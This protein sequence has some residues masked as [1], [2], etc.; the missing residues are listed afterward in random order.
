MSRGVLGSA[1]GSKKIRFTLILRFQ[2]SRKRE[3]FAYGTW[4]RFGGSLLLRESWCGAVGC[5]EGGTLTASK[6]LFPEQNAEETSPTHPA[7]A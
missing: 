6:M 1:A 4:Q 3:T 7:P 2:N 5:D